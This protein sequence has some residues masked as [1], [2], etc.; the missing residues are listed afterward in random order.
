MLVPSSGGGGHLSEIIWWVN[1]KWTTP[2]SRPMDSDSRGWT[3]PQFH[4]PE[5]LLANPTSFPAEQELPGRRD[6]FGGQ[7]DLTPD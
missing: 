4:S 6:N 3:E 2:L 5:M 7:G 1:I